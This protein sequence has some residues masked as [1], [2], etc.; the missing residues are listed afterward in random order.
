[1]KDQDKG[2]AHTRW[3]HFRLQVIGPLLVRP[4]RRGKLK[5]RL[6]QISHLL[7]MHPTRGEPVRFGTSTLERWYY[8]ALRAT[9]PVVVLRR[10]V[11]RDA[12]RARLLSARAQDALREQYQ[13]HP[14]WSWRL[15]Y[16]NLV[17]LAALPGDADLGRL[18]GYATVRRHM[19]H[20][21]MLRAPREEEMTAGEAAALRRIDEREVRS[22]EVTHVNALWHADFHVG[23]VRV[24]VD[25]EWRAPRCLCV[26]DD[27]SRLICHAQWYLA[28]NTENAVHGFCQAFMKYGLPRGLMTDNGSGFIAGETQEGLRRLSVVLE[29]TLA[30]S[31]YQNGKQES[32][33]GILEG[34]LL[35]MVRGLDGLTLQRLN[36]MTWAWV[37]QEYQV[38]EHSETGQ[39][40]LQ[41]FSDGPE[42]GRVSPRSFDELRGKFRR[43]EH[44]TQ[45]TSDGTISLH[46][47]RYEIPAQYRHLASVCVA[48]AK[49]DLDCVHLWDERNDRELSRIFP[50]DR[51]RNADGARRAVP[52]EARRLRP[53]VKPDGK[54]P[55][56]LQLLMDRQA[57]TGVPPAYLA[58]DEGKDQP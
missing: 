29:L 21:G 38:H 17:A 39:T 45:R 49:W 47:R 12:G 28:E 4:P 34:R 5:F 2:P 24:C 6:C 54:M 18:P 48:Y 20:S 32:A 33:W 13:Q 22:Y 25:G 44:R 11:R 46:G 16:D 1:M 51:A 15:H 7:Y 23:S 30:E 10:K 41:R 43:R 27:R 58:K 3:A 26:L 56:L 37:Q 53:R 9:D 52:V 35:A 19:K 42:V 31:P 14:D 36:E 57:K 8:R 55:P 40:P 50:L